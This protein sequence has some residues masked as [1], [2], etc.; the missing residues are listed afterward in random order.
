MIEG[1]AAR[2]IEDEWGEVTV[3]LELM[4]DDPALSVPLLM[5]PVRSAAHATAAKVR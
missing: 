5:Q 4:H 1:V 2:A 3:T